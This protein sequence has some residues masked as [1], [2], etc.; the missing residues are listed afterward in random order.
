L[1]EKF[2]KILTYKYGKKKK[3]KKKPREWGGWPTLFDVPLKISDAF[4]TLFPWN[5]MKCVHYFMQCVARFLHSTL[6][7]VDGHCS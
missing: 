6:W 7:L 5:R 4:Y 1:G 3:K 2:A